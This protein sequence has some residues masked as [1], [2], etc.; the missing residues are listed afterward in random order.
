MVCIIIML[1]PGG[2]INSNSRI[3]KGR[4]AEI[5]SADYPDL[6]ADIDLLPESDLFLDTEWYRNTLIR[7]VDLWNGGIDGQS[8]MG[9]YRNGFDGYFNVNLRRNWQSYNLP[10]ISAIAYSR[11][12][13]MNVEAYRAAGP[14]NG[15][16][17]MNVILKGTDFL[18]ENFLDTQYGGFYREVAGNGSVHSSYKQGY[19]NVHPMFVLAQVYSV[20][21]DPVHLDAAL[22]Q[23]RVLEDHFFD[24]DYAGAIL[25]GL[26]RDFSEEIGVK[27]IDLFTHY[28]EAL[29]ALFDVTEGKNHQWVTD[30]INE[31]GGLLTGRL[32]TDAQGASDSGYVAYNY[33]DEWLPSQIPYSR[34]QQWSGAMH[35]TP[36]HGIEFA[37]LLSRAVERGFDESWMDTAQK[38]LNFCIDHAINQETGGMLYDVLDYSGNPLPDNPDNPFYMWWPNAET[39]R[40]LLHY[41]VVRDDSYKGN[42][43]KAESF[44]H[45]NLT[46]REYGGFYNRVRESDLTADIM[47]KGSVWKINYHYSMFL[48]EALRLSEQYSSTVSELN[49][50]E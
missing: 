29:L 16:R 41:T 7:T 44:V 5:P 31:A 27:G 2:C 13:Y 30:K 10:Y 20:T 12:I 1:L 11:C 32:Y 15:S 46:D 4:E 17:F 50:P 40:A 39:A 23:L 21:N 37:Y 26:S 47:D 6:L 48:A 18:L 3:L 38:L 9:A 19:G 24:P 33:S 28:F 8:G 25:P 14:E 43:K 36:G 35:S 22:D 45:E 49:K 42:F 34:E